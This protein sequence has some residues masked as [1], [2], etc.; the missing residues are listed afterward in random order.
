MA[1][2]IAQALGAVLVVTGCVLIAPFV[3]FL[4]GGALLITLGIALEREGR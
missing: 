4:V 1:G 2:Y 3:G